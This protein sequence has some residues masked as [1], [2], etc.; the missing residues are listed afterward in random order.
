MPFIW[1]LFSAGS[2]KENESQSLSNSTVITV[3]I[4]G[5]LAVAIICLTAYL[6]LRSRNKR[7]QIGNIH[8]AT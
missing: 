7:R 6:I 5:V 8:V 2:G 3:A 1:F 4:S